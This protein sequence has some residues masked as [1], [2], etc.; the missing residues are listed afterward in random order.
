MIKKT[1]FMI[2]AFIAFFVYLH[3]KVTVY[4]EA[5]KLNESYKQLDELVD[6]R[7]DLLYNFSKRVSL[8]QINSWVD[9]NGLK[10][11]DSDKVMAFN[12]SNGREIKNSKMNIVFLSLKRIFRVSDGSKALAQE[13]N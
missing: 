5:Y 2:L 6:V 8:T 1:I 13:Q 4:I 10:V 3:Q 7:D 12:L 11:A 9:A